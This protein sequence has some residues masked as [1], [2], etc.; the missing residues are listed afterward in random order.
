MYKSTKYN[1]PFVKKNSSKSFIYAIEKGAH[2]LIK[3]LVELDIQQLPISE[4]NR[5]YIKSF[6]KSPIGHIQKVFIFALSRIRSCNAR[7]RDLTVIDYGGG[8]GI[9]SLLA[10]EMGIGKV[11]YN[12]IYDVS[13]DDIEITA[14][15]LDLKL[16]HIVCGGIE[17][18]ISHIQEHDLRVDAIV[19]YD[20]IEHI[21]IYI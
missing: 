8:S 1:F 4:Y 14:K 10:K 13:C 21:Y 5:Q 12:D 2:R 20:V 9:M 15:K 7:L 6:L 11:I 17:C 18:L 16:D 3:K 19:S